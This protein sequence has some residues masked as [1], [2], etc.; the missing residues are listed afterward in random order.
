MYH[1]LA[2]L[3]SSFSSF[4]SLAISA[5]LGAR[6]LH[7]L[8]V[9]LRSLLADFLQDLFFF[10]DILCSD[11]LGAL[12]EHVFEKM[13][14][15]RFPFAVVDGT[16]QIAD[17]EGDGRAGVPFHQQDPQAVLQC[18]PLHP[19]FQV[20]G[21]QC[22]RGKEDGKDDRN[23]S[24]GDEPQGQGAGFSLRWTHDGLFFSLYDLLR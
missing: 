16:H 21:R 14:G 23:Q 17:V 10:L 5:S 9:K 6:P 1:S 12:E 20:V 11:G 2:S 13:G 22:S 3:C 8:A 15:A 7:P 18:N 4:A 19:I 24:G